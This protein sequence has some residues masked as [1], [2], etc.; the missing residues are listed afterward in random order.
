MS[1]LSRRTI[2]TMFGG[3]AIGGA[4]GISRA[5]EDPPAA[6]VKPVAPAAPRV[7]FRPEE[8]FRNGP[9]PIAPGGTTFVLLPDTQNYA[10]SYPEHYKAQTRWIVEQKQARNIAAVMH[11]GDITNQNT[12]DQWKNADAAMT[13]L[14]G[15]VP[16][17]AALGNHDYGPRGNCST[18]QTFMGEYFP[19]KRMQDQATRGGARMGGV[20]PEEPDRP[21]NA[22]YMIEAAGRQWLVICLE[23]GPRDAVVEWA[24]MVAADHKDHSA[25]LVTHAYMFNDE[26][27][28]HWAAKGKRQTWNPHDYGV[29]KLPGGVNDGQELWN[30]LVKKNP[31][32]VLTLN[33]HVLG[34]GLAKLTSRHPAGHQ[35]HQHLVNFQM[36]PQGGDGWLR[37]L[38]IAAN[39]RGVRVFDYSPT[40]DVH[41]INPDNRFNFNL[42]PKRA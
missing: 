32:F 37:L 19:I 39:G 17:F 12:P 26:T 40:L 41:N 27:R 11:L 30:K 18:R 36:K 21:E 10:Q 1:Q 4:A 14:E 5:F 35:V 24:N 7:I 34:D 6:P 33:G 20:F 15:H 22:Y 16:Y 9:P 28:Y 38:N 31:N 23:F 3:A 2:L 29:A 8:D 25:I 13:L 42:A